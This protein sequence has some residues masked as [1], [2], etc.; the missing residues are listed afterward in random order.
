[1]KS[2]DESP[3]DV[4]GILLQRIRRVV[5]LAHVIGCDATGESLE[6][7]SHLRIA[8]QRLGARDRNGV[9]RRELA[10][11]VLELKEIE[12]FD[13]ACCSIARDQ[14]NLP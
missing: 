4:G 7:F 1:M 2:L 6:R 12:S 9:V 10:A 3:R 14:I 11:V 13:Q 5:H 8:Q